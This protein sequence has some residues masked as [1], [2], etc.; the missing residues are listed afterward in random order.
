MITKPRASPSNTGTDFIDCLEKFTN[1]QTGIIMI[2]EI[3][4]N[5]EEDALSG[6]GPEIEQTRCGIHCGYGTSDVVWDMPVRS[7]PEVRVLR[8]QNCCMEDAGK[9]V[10]L[11]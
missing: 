3:G 6:S 8:V 11:I 2:G 10:T 4:G 5:A 9:C 1:D 7:F